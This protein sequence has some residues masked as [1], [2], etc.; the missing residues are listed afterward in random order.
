MTAIAL[1]DSFIHEFYDHLSVDYNSEHNVM[2]YYMNP[3]PRPCFTPFL[4]EEINKFQ[5]SVKDQVLNELKLYGKTSINYLV[6]ASSAQGVFN[7]GGDLNLFVEL[8]RNKDRSALSKYAH[9]SI[10][11]L[12]SNAINLG[13]PITTVALVQG[14]A[15]GAGFESALS[16]DV[17]VAEKN[18]QFG[19][20][21][22]LFNM[23]PGMGAYSFLARRLGQLSVEKMIMSG[24]IYSAHELYEMGIIDVLADEG[25][26]ENALYDFVRKS[27]KYRNTCRYIKRI[28]ERVNPVT[29][30]ELIDI[31]NLWVDAAISL[32][33]KDLKIMERIVKAQNR[34]TANI[35]KV[36]GDNFE[37]CK[38]IPS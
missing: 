35:T 26:G 23:F 29:H 3:K 33:E 22:V 25:D 10:D 7:L 19:F 2:I 27:S 11:V 28:R 38:L 24:R 30:E 17:I 16:C 31:A 36:S 34:R 32:S 37:N 21:E 9:L 15:L 6:L 5:R 8:I 4:L 20:P 18:V 12:Y 13:L 1:K 14:N